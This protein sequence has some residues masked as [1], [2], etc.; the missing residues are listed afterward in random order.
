MNSVPLLGL[1]LLLPA[2]A[3]LTWLGLLFRSTRR[4]QMLLWSLLA[5]LAALAGCVFG[6]AQ[7]GR[8]GH[9]LWP[10]VAAATAAFI[11]FL[12]VWSLGLWLSRPRH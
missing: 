10:Q 11:A 4:R 2:F 12:S 7:P 3:L 1:L 5:L 6:E 8:G 9:V